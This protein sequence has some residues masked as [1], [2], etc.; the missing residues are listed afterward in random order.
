LNHSESVQ[1][2]RKLNKKYNVDINGNKNE[3]I[4]YNIN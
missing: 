4:I 2:F 1:V 3:N